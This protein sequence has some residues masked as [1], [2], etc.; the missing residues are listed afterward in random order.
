MFDR[1]KICISFSGGRTSAVMTDRLLREYP[2]KE[3][4]I[5][6]ANTGMEHPDTLRFVDACDR[7]L[8]GGKVVWLEAVVHQEHGKGNTYKVV[9]YETAARNGEPYRESV[10]KY[11]L[12]NPTNP[13]CTARVK[14][15]PM[16]K[17]L[18]DRGFL[19]G[20]NNRNYNTAIGIRA[21]E[22]DRISSERE[23]Y[24]LVYPLIRWGVTKQQVLAKCAEWDFDLRID[25]HLGNCVGCFKKSL[26]KLATVSID[27]PEAFK[28]WEEMEDTFK[29][30]KNDINKDPETGY[31]R[32]YR[33]NRTVSD[34]FKEGRKEGFRPFR[35]ET[36][37]F[38][39]L[40]VQ[41]G[42]GESCEVYSDQQL[43]FDIELED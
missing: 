23:K 40:D 1:D 16:R 18:K 38:D 13:S 34:I 6:F 11:G 43:L 10:T 20:K 42:C 14:I 2:D 32:M 21:D 39:K 4:I 17:Y 31:R 37:T 41:G 36:P 24:G 28:V 15:V 33:G 26:R 12:F 3:V 35:S 7:E 25:E 29:D 5:T 19:L 30:F 27:L 22:A 8:F 9:D